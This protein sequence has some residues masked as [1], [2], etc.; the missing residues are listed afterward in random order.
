MSTQVSLKIGMDV[1]ELRRVTE[2]VEQLGEEEDWSPPLILRLNLVLE[3]LGMN[4]ISYGDPDGANP[5]EIEF[6]LTSEAEAV[7]IDI[8]D[9][10][11]AFNPFTDAPAP[12][13]DASLLDRRVGGLGIYL[14]QTMMDDVRYRRENGKNHVTLV[15]RRSP[16]SE[17]TND[18][19]HPFP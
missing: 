3:E 19:S 14:T 6:I 15:A 5:H 12:D 9:D 8:I 17:S 10:C 1:Q 16:Q 11:K 7:T 13:L 4:V 2:A 18:S